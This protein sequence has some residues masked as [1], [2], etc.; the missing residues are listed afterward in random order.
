MKSDQKQ[1][2][3]LSSVFAMKC[4]RCREGDLFKTPTFSYQ[5]PTEMPDNC[6]VCNQSYSPEP[7]FWYG[8]MFIS[9]IWTAWACLFFVGGGIFLFGMSVNGA[10]A[11]LIVVVAIFFFWIFRISRSMWIHIYVKYNPE[12]KEKYQAKQMAAIKRGS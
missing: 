12:A 2:S 7:G 1:R 3:V 9:Y 5:K 8:A 4:P 10:F 11:L 6:P